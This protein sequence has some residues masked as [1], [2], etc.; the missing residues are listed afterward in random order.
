MVKKQN[1]NLFE[2]LIKI[3]LS[4]IFVYSGTIKILNPYQFSKV[5]ESYGFNETVSY[6]IAIIFPSIEITFGVS[7]LITTRLFYLI[8][9]LNI[10]YSILHLLKMNQFLPFGCGCFSI[11]K[12]GFANISTFLLSILL[13]ILTVILI[14]K[15]NQ[16][17]I[18]KEGG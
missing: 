11:S 18:Y 1:I 4:L 13:V 10:G 17:E 9:F 16:K 15:R 6:L 2:F 12:P 14:I 8:L 3:V 7:I 5:L